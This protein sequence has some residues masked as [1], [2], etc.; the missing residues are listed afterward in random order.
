MLDLYG[1]EGKPWDTHKFKELIKYI[2]VGDIS[3]WW[4][5]YMEVYKNEYILWNNKMLDTLYEKINEII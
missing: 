4:K 3:Y 5:M 1:F 2:E